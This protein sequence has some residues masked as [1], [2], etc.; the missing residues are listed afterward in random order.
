MQVSASKS[1]C[2]VDDLENDTGYVVK[3][4]AV[5]KWALQIIITKSRWKVVE[6]DVS[7]MCETDLLLYAL[8]VK[9]VKL[10]YC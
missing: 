6:N 9:L 1:S 7:T 8:R 10:S 2:T 5:N 3:V 4:S